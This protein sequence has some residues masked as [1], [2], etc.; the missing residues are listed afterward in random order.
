MVSLYRRSIEPYE[1]IILI[2]QA[3]AQYFAR[4]RTNKKAI[5]DRRWYPL[6]SNLLLN[7]TL[8]DTMA[9]N[10]KEKEA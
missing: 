10:G 3:W 1:I 2:N 5:A 9:D 7:I 4:A 8:R 6:N